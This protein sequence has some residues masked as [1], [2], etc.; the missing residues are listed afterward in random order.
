MQ[1]APEARY[2]GID[3]LVEALQPYAI[4]TNPGWIPVWQ[5]RWFTLRGVEPRLAVPGRFR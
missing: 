1:K 5:P 4:V 2:P 3:E